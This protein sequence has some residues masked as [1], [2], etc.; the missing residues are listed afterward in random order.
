LKGEASTA[1][2]SSSQGSRKQEKT[3]EKG[4]S[5]HGSKRKQDGKLRTKK[6]GKNKGKREQRAHKQRKAGGK[7]EAKEGHC[8]AIIHTVSRE[9][10][11]L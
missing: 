1:F 9:Q 10:V 8:A 7:A 4:N 6:A 2:S 3:K 11:S 5:G